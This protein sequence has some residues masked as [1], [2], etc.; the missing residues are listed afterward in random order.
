MGQDADRS[1]HAL[2]RIAARAVHKGESA[3]L[4]NSCDDPPR[5]FGMRIARDGTWFYLES[6][7]HR[8]PL[9][10]LFASVLQR[11]EDGRYWLITPVER[12]I[13]QVDDAPFVAV[14]VTVS[15]SG[16][17]AVPGSELSFVTNLGE[18]V[19]A[20]PEH[21]IRVALDPD[22]GEPTPYILVRTGLE[23]LINRPTYYRLV[24]MA[25]ERNGTAGPEVGVWSGDVFFA[26]DGGDGG[27]AG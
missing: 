24:E 27:E 13:I 7:I 26:L 5:D 20:G 21:P 15:P 12:G 8:M 1:I 19:V 9:V 22:S 25:V 23:A 10:K 16:D 17:V 3:T 6:P 4:P 18:T 11:G 14:D 2:E